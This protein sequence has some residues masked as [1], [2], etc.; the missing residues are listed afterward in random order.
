[1]Q[2]PQGL[3]VSLPMDQIVLADT[4]A[5]VRESVLVRVRDLLPEDQLSPARS[6][7]MQLDA[8]WVETVWA[9]GRQIWRDGRTYVPQNVR[10]GPSATLGALNAGRS[11]S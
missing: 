7:R 5:V 3:R 11:R 8:H 10:E 6:H 9:E 2:F 1:M 4:R